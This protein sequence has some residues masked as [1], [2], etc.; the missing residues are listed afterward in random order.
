MNHLNQVFLAVTRTTDLAPTYIAP[1]DHT[2][3]SW[4]LVLLAAIV[5]IALFIGFGV[6]LSAQRRVPAM[7]LAD[8]VTLELCRAHGLGMPHRAV[9]ELIRKRAGIGHTAELFLS[10]KF[11]DAAV[12]QASQS[13]RLGMRQRGLVFEARRSLFE[14]A[15]TS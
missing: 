3:M 7:I 5:A 2:G 6:W 8:D 4:G 15:A 11:F 12:N 9:L 10:A 13:K 14:S 1:V